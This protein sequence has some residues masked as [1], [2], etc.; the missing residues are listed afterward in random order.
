MDPEVKY[1]LSLDAVRDRAKEVG[2]EAAA[3]RLNH[4]IVNEARLSDVAD[5]VTSVIKASRNLCLPW[6]HV[7]HTR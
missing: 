6:V 5:F 2:I 1:L 7:S 4:F 3:G